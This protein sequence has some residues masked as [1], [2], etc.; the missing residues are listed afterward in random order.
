MMEIWAIDT[1]WNTIKNFTDFEEAECWV[2]SNKAIQILYRNYE[3]APIHV[4]K[5]FK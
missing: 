3:D 2:P 5:S 1:N 4:F